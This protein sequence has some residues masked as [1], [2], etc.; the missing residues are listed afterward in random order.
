MSFPE[1]APTAAHADREGFR[2]ID[3]RE[4]H[5]F[6]GPLGSVPGSEL[7]PLSTVAENVEQLSDSRP[8]LLV[9]RSGV[10]SGKACSA[11]QEL[12]IQSVA[13]LAGGM[14]AWNRAGLPVV[15]TEPRTLDELVASVV[16]WLAQ[17]T[18]TSRSDA[19]SRFDQLI[20]AAG[21]TTS[22]LAPA[23]LSRALEALSA[24]LE[25]AGAPPDLG[26]T[27]DAYQ[28]DLAVLQG[29]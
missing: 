15:R 26:L 14:I 21:A 1:L 8:L 3:V 2:I 5:E 27:M 7:I 13:N 29:P 12:G 25:A 10:R 28:R 20:L 24:E 11:L 17:V 23:A 18:A 19:R 16:A 22:E 6:H 9:C 4:E